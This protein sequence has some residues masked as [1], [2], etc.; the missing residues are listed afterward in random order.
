MNSTMRIMEGASAAPVDDEPSAAAVDDEL[1]GIFTEGSRGFNVRDDMI[2]PSSL[3]WPVFMTM[4]GFVMGSAVTAL[5]FRIPRSLS[6]IQGRSACPSCHAPLQ[7]LDL[8]P[9]LSF[10][11]ARG[12]CR[13]CGA[14]IG[15]RYPL[16]EVVC[17]AWTLLVY[18]QLGLTAA[19]PLLALWGYLLVA[20]FWI[21]LDFQLLP[22][23]LTLPGTL[24]AAAAA[25]TVPGGARAA[26]LGIL[27][28]SGALWL[29]AW[30][31]LRVRKIEG[32]G[33]G[34]IKLAA[35]FG[36]VLGW[37]RTLLTLFLAALMGSLWGGWLI[38]RRSG[39]GQTPLPF[40]TLL[41]P[42]AM[43]TF[44]WGESWIGAYIGL[45]VTR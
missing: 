45:F 44:L 15:W 36:A 31:Y 38:A 35:M 43:A 14:P 9:V 5:S 23:V 10:A 40:G 39:G 25:L 19:L 13:H 30:I 33:G 42:A 22:D 27:V 32:M 12:R 21:D 29:V 6:W 4:V 34:D 11:L 17:G 28:G 1:V 16:T 3:F 41:V 20:L 8:I 2:E 26:L 18:R 24:L 7:V 37:E